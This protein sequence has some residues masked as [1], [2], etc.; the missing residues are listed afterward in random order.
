MQ[1][2]ETV[3]HDMR[4]LLQN[5]QL[6]VL[7]TE[8]HGQPYAERLRDMPLLVEGW[9]AGIDTILRSAPCLVVAMA[10]SGDRNGMVNLTLALFY[11]ELTAPLY[12]IGTCWA[13]LLQAAL[14][15]I[16][17][18]K[19]Q[20]SIPADYPFHYPMMIG[21]AKRHYYRRPQRKAPRISRG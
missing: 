7:S 4:Q 13:G 5:E 21:Y 19:Q 11:L 16:P 1:T 17:E 8:Q 14:M 2:R 12:G 3:E 9:D 6:G 18:L 20:I 15:S 10:P